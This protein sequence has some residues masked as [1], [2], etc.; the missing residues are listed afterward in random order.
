MKTERPRSPAPVF[1]DRIGAAGAA[2]WPL[3]ERYIHAAQVLFPGAASGGEERKFG[4][5]SFVP[6]GAAQS[7]ISRSRIS[8]VA[9]DTSASPAENGLSS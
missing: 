2:L 1:G 3:T 8:I 6:S 4:G 7:G 9:D 5:D